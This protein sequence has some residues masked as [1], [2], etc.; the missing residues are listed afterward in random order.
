MSTNKLSIQALTNAKYLEHDSHKILNIAI[1]NQNVIALGYLPDEETVDEINLCHHIIVNNAFNIGLFS[2]NI[3][4][5]TEPTHP[6]ITNANLSPID[7]YELIKHINSQSLPETDQCYV[8]SVQ[9]SEC[10]FILQEVTKKP[11]KSDCHLILEY[12]DEETCTILSSIKLPECLSL[13]IYLTNAESNYL[14]TIEHLI[15]N[16]TIT[17][18]SCEPSFALCSLIMKQFPETY[19]N[20]MSLLFNDASK[21]VFK[22]TP[23]PIEIG[24]KINAVFVQK[25]SPHNIPI[26][27]DNGI[28]LKLQGDNNEAS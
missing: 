22:L 26:V 6:L 7:S 11:L 24:K 2:K 25:N 17:S 19:Q 14:T 1:K 18:V 4:S 3:S 27:V 9:V 13:G 20:I 16:K 21:T 5:K 23:T 15:L 10:L 12:L 8:S 28:I